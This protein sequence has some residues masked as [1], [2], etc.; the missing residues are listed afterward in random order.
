M[1]KAAILIKSGDVS[2]ILPPKH[3]NTDTWVLVRPATTGNTQCEFFVTEMRQ[4]GGADWDTHPGCEH[5]YYVMAGRATMSVEDETYDL[6]PGD[7]LLMREGVRHKVEVVGSETF[8]IAVVFAPG[9]L[10]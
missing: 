5:I 1:D 9:R 8:R 4:G 2:P 10:P 7:C 3:E 6:E